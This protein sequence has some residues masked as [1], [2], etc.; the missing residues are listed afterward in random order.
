MVNAHIECKR[1]LDSLNV[2]AKDPTSNTAIV[3][4]LENTTK[5]KIFEN[6]SQELKENIAEEASV[7]K[8]V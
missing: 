4:L 1:L 3:A 5:D 8:C 2:E 7:S 6:V